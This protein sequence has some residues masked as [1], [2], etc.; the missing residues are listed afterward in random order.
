MSEN[1][2]NGYANEQ[3]TLS[4]SDWFDIDAYLGVDDY[5]S[6]KVSFG[7]IK[8]QI[9][10]QTS[11]VYNSSGT[12]TG[13]RTIDTDGNPLTFDNVV[14]FFA[15]DSTNRGVR[16]YEVL[17][18]KYFVLSGEYAN[19]QM[20]QSI[21]NPFVINI[22]APIANNRKGAKYFQDY[23]IGWHFFPKFAVK[24]VLLTPIK[25]RKIKDTI[26]NTSVLR[27]LYTGCSICVFIGK[28]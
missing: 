23:S 14:N 15:V 21:D 10:S 1:N 20:S 27:P 9:L 11:N 4:D 22:E 19:I 18:V 8:N 6:K 26:S 3:T 2:I 12:L 24:S 17:G 25:P 16:K 7:T 28:R 5:E 13:A